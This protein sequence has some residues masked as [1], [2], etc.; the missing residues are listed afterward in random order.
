PYDALS[1]G[2]DHLAT[3]PLDPAWRE[4]LPEVRQQLDALDQILR[5]AA[6][7][8]PE[9]R[10]KLPGLAEVRA[11]LVRQIDAV[12]PES[13]LIDFTDTDGPP[14][15]GSRESHAGGSGRGVGSGLGAGRGTA[16]GPV[17]LIPSRFADDA[18]AR[19]VYPWLTLVNPSGSDTN[20]VLTVIVSDMNAAEGR[21]ASWQAPPES[22]QPE[23]HLL[24][25]QRQRLGLSDEAAPPV[26]RTDVEAVR[27]AMEAARPG[28][29]GVLLVRDP[30]TAAGL[31]GTSHAFNVL[32][33]EDGVVFLDGQHGGLARMPAYAGDLLFLPLS[34]DVPRPEGA[35]TVDPAELSGTAGT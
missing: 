34:E 33:D 35:P 18:A 27:T 19:E 12:V 28:S 5:A 2:L 25:Y 9:L 26:Y 23:E 20:C 21:N 32:R 8:D 24:N 6:E 30:V 4:R 3:G 17:R 13:S 14:T 7:T 31:G 1:A 22:A 11:D 10:S 29:R 16:G 15:D